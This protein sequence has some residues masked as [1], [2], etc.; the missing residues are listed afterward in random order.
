MFLT[1]QPLQDMVIGLPKTGTVSTR[2]PAEDINA[3]ADKLFNTNK[4]QSMKILTNRTAF[5]IFKN[6]T[7]INNYGTVSFKPYNYTYGN[8][9]YTDIQG[10]PG[11]EWGV[12]YLH[13]SNQIHSI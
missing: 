3:E 5:N 4:M 8:D 6:N 9:R 10:F 2:N 7:W 11:L 12:D 1:P 13:I